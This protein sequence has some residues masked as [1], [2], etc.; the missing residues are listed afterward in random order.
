M[1]GLKRTPDQL[2]QR[3]LLCDDL[4]WLIQQDKDIAEELID[5]YVYL[6]NDT[7]VDELITLC[8]DEL[9]EE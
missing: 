9:G 5:E 3:R 7:R 1:N 6:L 2:K 8:N 4:Y